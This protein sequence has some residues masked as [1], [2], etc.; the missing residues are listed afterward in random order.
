MSELTDI[1]KRILL[2][3]LPLDE[4]PQ[5][6]DPTFYHTLRYEDEMKLWRQCK[7]IE[8]KLTPEPPEGG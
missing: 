8:A 6:L 3:F 5:G 1:E 2:N 7:A 4:P